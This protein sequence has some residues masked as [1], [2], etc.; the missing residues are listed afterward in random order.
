MRPSAST[1]TASPLNAAASVAGTGEYALNIGVNTVTLTV[2]AESGASETYT[3]S[4]H[5]RAPDAP[6]TITGPYA[7]SA[8]GRVSGVAPGTALAAFTS[9]LGVSGG[10]LT[11]TDASGAARRRKRRCVPA[12]L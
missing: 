5:R 7:F 2:T 6:V 1:V 9:S 11:V 4:V 8:D 3:L 10:T 12:I